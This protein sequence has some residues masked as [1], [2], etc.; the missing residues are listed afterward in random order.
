MALTSSTVI[1]SSNQ[2]TE[3]SNTADY[4]PLLLL[5]VAATV[6]YHYSKKQM[7]KARHKML[8]QIMKMKLKDM[9]SFR[10]KKGMNTGLKAV[11]IAIVVGVAF[12]LI[13]SLAVGAGAFVVALLFV[14]LI[15]RKGD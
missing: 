8:W 13:F 5:P 2:K 7:R 10:K 11:L 15:V 12:G 14:P 9:F 4:S 1:I 3:T 6:A